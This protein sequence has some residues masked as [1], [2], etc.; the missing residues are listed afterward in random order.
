MMASVTSS[1]LGQVPSL[2]AAEPTEAAVAIE[3]DKINSINEFL[4]F[5]AQSIPDTPLIAYPSS[6][7]GAS[8]FVDYTAKQLDDYADSAAKA[9]NSQGLKPTKLRSTKADVVG[10]LG[11][12][13]LDYIINLL[14]LSRMGF[15]VLFLSTRLPTEAYVS[16]LQK[17][18][19]TRIIVAPN[20]EAVAANIQESYPLQSFPLISQSVWSHNTSY[21]TRFKRQTELIDEENTVSFIVHSSGSTGLPKPIY[22][23][24]RQCL[25]NYAIGSG[26]RAFVTLPLFHN[27]GLSTMFRGMVTGKRTA[28]YNANLPLTNGHLVAAMNAA[29]FESFHC[30][31]YALKVLAETPE[32]IAELAKAKLVLFGGSSCPDDLGDTLVQNGVNVVSHYGAT[33][34][35]QLMTSLRDPDTDKAWNYVRP[36]IKTKP[37]L[38]FDEVTTDIFE[39]VV[40]DGLTTKTTSNSDDPPNSFRTRDT[41][42]KHPT[43]PNAWKY[44]GRLD[45]RVTL[46]NGEKVLPVPYEHH[47]RQSELVQECLVFG[48]GKAFAGLLI[49][50]GDHATGISD[51]ELLDTL[52]PTIQDANQKAEQFGRI[53]R[54]MVEILPIGTEYPRTD[55]GTVIRAACYKHFEAI[56]EEKYRKFESPGNADR[57]A[58][59]LPE[60]REYLLNLLAERIGVT[61]L[62]DEMDFFAAGLD[63]LQAITTRAYIVRELD[64]GGKIPGQNVVF[65]HPSVLQLAAHLLSLRKGSTVKEKTETEIMQELVAKY[66]SFEP[67]KRG[68]EVPD[69]EVVLLTG[70]TGSLGAHILSQLIALPRV[71]HVYCLVRASSPLAAQERVL[72]SLSSR[73]LTPH[74]SAAHERIISS[75]TEGGLS[76]YHHSAKFTALPADLG[77]PDLGLGKDAYDALRSTLTS[78]IHS[79]WAVNFTLTVK[80]FEGQHIAGLRHLLDLCLSVP[81]SRPARLSFISSISAAAGTPSPG[82]VA[83]TLVK[84]PAHAQNMGY[85]RSKWVAEHIIHAAAVA[86]GI[87]ARVLRSGQIIGD[88]AMGLWNPTEAIPLMFRAAVTLGA[89]PS[90]DE[91]PSWLPVDKSAQAVLELSGLSASGNQTAGYFQ[92]QDD[93]DVVYHLQNPTTVRWTEDVLPAMAA[94]GLQFEIVGQRDW[95]QR[96]RDGEQDP[97]LNPTIKLL[98]FFAEKYDNDKPGRGGLVFETGETEKR[99][100]AIHDGYDVVSSGLLAKCVTSWKKHWV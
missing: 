19:C 63:S 100:N 27:H 43:I 29:N 57:L 81:F 37:F 79:A 61:N 7:L 58:L 24:H 23:T 88:S 38:L 45:D 94:A 85:A 1:V 99:S 31:P 44:L 5:Q 76:S 51:T 77:L 97:K 73:G 8:D 96:L 55:K 50:P 30:V 40:L 48:V 49:I 16:L 65:E 3:P 66:S 47:V 82:R 69:G 70:A 15:S 80:S 93:A 22:Q 56:I 95:V 98:D 17:T 26:M 89:L 13:N 74:H 28:V 90:L 92:I 34:M 86:T 14:A 33:E 60:L 75:L 12:S 18:D 11:P 64:L 59:E 46:F 20:L 4:V 41:F 62:S 71:R 25:S 78:V 52:W 42:V 54:E 84:D 10:I 87:E 2:D 39:L 83:E 9:L 91:N 21:S 67:F 35:G 32:G 68:T 53:S 36:L 72:D 6:K